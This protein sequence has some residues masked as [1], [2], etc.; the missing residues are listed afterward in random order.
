MGVPTAEFH[1]VIVA[2]RPRRLPNRRRQA[3]SQVSI[4]ELVDKSHF[5]PS[6]VSHAL[7]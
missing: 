2:I 5:A 3:L 4:T 6:A 7:A 1:E